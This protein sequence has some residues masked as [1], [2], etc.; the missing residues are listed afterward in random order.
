ML[1]EYGYLP[2]R[3]NN[4][5][6]LIDIYNTQIYLLSDHLLMLGAMY[7]RLVHA[8]DQRKQL[9]Q[10]AAFAH[11]KEALDARTGGGQYEQNVD[12]LVEAGGEAD[13]G[14]N[15]GRIDDVEDCV[16]AGTIDVVPDGTAG[17]IPEAADLPH[18]E[19]V[20]HGQHGQL[21]GTT[22]SAAAGCQLFAVKTSLRQLYTLFLFVWTYILCISNYC[23]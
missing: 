9:P 22:S 14:G 16:Q 13:L 18:R 6:K 2:L 20:A 12:D 7:V 1:S 4:N 17:Q 11:Y 15:A 21:H 10:L 23:N 5:F 8:G 3:F 19:V